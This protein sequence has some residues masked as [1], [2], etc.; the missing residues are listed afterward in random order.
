MTLDA[1]SA[2]HGPG[3]GPTPLS[4]LFSDRVGEELSD[5]GAVAAGVD[6]LAQVLRTLDGI[7]ATELAASPGGRAL[8]DTSLGGPPEDEGTADQSAASTR[9]EEILDSASALFAE[10]G[11]HGS[12]LRDISRRVG[13]SHPGMLHHFSS[14]G[15]LLNAVID[16]LE[17]HAQGLLDSVEVL[18]TSPQSLI[19]ALTG[20]WDP[21]QHSM[22]LLAT[23]SAEVVNPDHPGR[24]RIARL[25]LVHEYVLEQVLTGLA[26]NDCLVPKADPKFLAR[27]L[28]SLLMSLTVRE[29]TV[30]ELQKTADGDP[31]A[32]VRAFVEQL[33]SE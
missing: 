16:R 26:E 20:P 18:Q 22:A 14:K 33:I 25:R 17:A 9:R 24:F 31:A 27:T 15:A 6:P 21:R 3:T 2:P 1:A 23:L 29:R 12:S 11:Y 28:F 32:D 8:I 4:S 13:I 5:G 19:A 10:R 7:S 30:R